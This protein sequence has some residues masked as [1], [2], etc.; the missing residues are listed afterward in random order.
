[1]YHLAYIWFL[2]AEYNKTLEAKDGQ[3]F[4]FSDGRTSRDMVFE[5]RIRG[6]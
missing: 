2:M 5:E 3:C 6:W 1:M 4:N